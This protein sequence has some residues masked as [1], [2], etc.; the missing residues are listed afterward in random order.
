MT[1][2][3][4]KFGVL[5]LVVCGVL[6]DYDYLDSN[7]QEMTEKDI[8]LHDYDYDNLEED[9]DDHEPSEYY[10]TDTLPNENI[11]QM[12]TITI[13][14]FVNE[15]KRRKEA[16]EQKKNFSK[17][18]T[19]SKSA[20]RKDNKKSLNKKSTKKKQSYGNGK[21]S[22]QRN[23]KTNTK[24]KSITKPK[25][26][27]LNK[28]QKKSEKRLNKIKTK[29]SRKQ[30]PFHKPKLIE[31][32]DDFFQIGNTDSHQHSDHH[33]HQH[34]H[35]EAHKHH[36]KHKES[37]SHAHDHSNDHV[38]NHK[39]THNHVHNHI[40][41]HNEA[42]EHSATHS[43]TEKHH[44]KHLEYI[45]AGGW[46]RR[47]DVDG[48]TMIEDEPSEEL[49][50]QNRSFGN[51]GN[52]KDNV[53]S[54]LK[55]YIEFYKTAATAGVKEE[56]DENL[57]DNFYQGNR[58]HQKFKDVLSNNS[59]EKDNRKDFQ[60][61]NNEELEEFGS[62]NFDF[63]LD[64]SEPKVS[65]HQAQLLK[66]LKD[67]KNAEEDVEEI[68]F[69]E[70]VAL[71]KKGPIFEE[72]YEDDFDESPDVQYSS[73]DYP[74]YEDQLG[75]GSRNNI[76]QQNSNNFHWKNSWIPELSELVPIQEQE[77]EL[78]D[79]NQWQPQADIPLERRDTNEHELRGKEQ[80]KQT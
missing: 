66:L 44:H 74:A 77:I 36:H 13:E 48:G 64:H 18:N 6:T 52:Q 19:S 4:L 43:H 45:D 56:E 67:D 30:K 61:F 41:K 58:N 47:N 73:D 23:K 63:D 54:F 55:K 11:E 60:G 16:K 3:C 29:P 12:D 17:K 38:H 80:M 62:E 35:L 68:S 59:S 49:I 70:F 15:L 40:H 34:D 51:S 72:E 26:S 78:Y 8:A 27:T 39:H 20:F 71:Q 50:I 65:E 46:R 32:E 76:V 10:D 37:H 14:Q 5:C 9:T 53:K 2:F 25:K 31:E 42:H 7:E 69:E 57:S 1:K 22:T 28:L 75:F 79:E 24:K 33:I 21:I